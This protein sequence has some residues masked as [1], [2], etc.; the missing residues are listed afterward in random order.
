MREAFDES[1]QSVRHDL[2]QMAEMV[3]QAVGD[4]TIALLEA[5]LKLAERVISADA[6]LDLL[7]ERVEEQSYELI[8]LQS[9]VATDL[10]TLIAALKMAGELERMGDLAVHVAKVARMRI[11]ETAVPD[12]LEPTIGRMAS[13]AEVMVGK[14]A[15]IIADNDVAS[16]RELDEI[17]ETMDKL[18]RK[19]FREL[20]KSDWQHGIEAAVD[21]ALLGRY[22]ERIADHAVSISQRIIFLVTGE[23]HP[24]E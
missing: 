9:P 20:F 3:R 19:S 21:V 7:R 5:N 18:R 15:Q 17:D 22:Y 10:R 13:L 11:P 23:Q 6:E 4:A 14:V 8:N 1:L 12:Q 24:T 16:A 2:V